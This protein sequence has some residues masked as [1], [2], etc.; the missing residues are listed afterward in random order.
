ML[1]GV[2]ESA[3]FSSRGECPASSVI[4]PSPT[5]MLPWLLHC[6]ILISHPFVW[7]RV[8]LHCS[9]TLSSYVLF[10]FFC[11][12]PSFF[13]PVFFSLLLLSS[14]VW[15]CMYV[16]MYVGFVS[17]C[18]VCVCVFSPAPSVD[19]GSFAD[20][21]STWLELLRLKAHTIRR[22]SVKT[23]MRTQS[24]AHTG[25]HAHTQ[26][27]T[28]A[29]ACIHTHPSQHAAGGR[30]IG[31]Q[32]PAYKLECES[33]SPAPQRDT[34]SAAYLW[35]LYSHSEHNDGQGTRKL[36]SLLP[37]RCPTPFSKAPV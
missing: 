26:S 9:Q 23:S 11:F 32:T 31:N 1:P 37:N 18:S 25:D 3:N 12:F 5:S 20:R 28:Y 4:S 19:Y 30:S 27:L 17:V 14:C 24:L 8:I 34:P 33:W 6:P 22:G 7:D 16:C 29:H 10:L 35:N 15:V 36:F 21:C 2:P 13:C